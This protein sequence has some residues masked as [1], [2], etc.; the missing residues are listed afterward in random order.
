NALEQINTQYWIASFP[1]GPEV[2][3]N[4]RRTG[5]P[6]LTPNPY[7]GREVNFIKRL[8]YP[9]SEGSVNAANV[10]EAVQRMGPDALDT[11]VWWDTL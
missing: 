9:V 6:A 3:A 8:T 7:P 1:G 11:R 4:Y 10:N 5:Y 2:F